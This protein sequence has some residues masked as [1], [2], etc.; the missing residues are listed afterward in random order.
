VSRLATDGALLRAALEAGRAAA[1][2]T[3]DPS[4]APP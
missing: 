2:A 4:A 3:L 1:H